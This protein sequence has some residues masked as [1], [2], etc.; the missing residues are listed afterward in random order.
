MNITPVN[1][2]SFGRQVGANTLIRLAGNNI[3]GKPLGKSYDYGAKAIH[4]I[5]D[6]DMQRSTSSWHNIM[7]KAADYI[8]E[9]FPEI[10][11]TAKRITALPVD[12]RNGAEIEKIMNEYTSKFGDVVEVKADDFKRAVLGPNTPKFPKQKAKTQFA[13]E[14][15]LPAKAKPETIKP[16]K[17]AAQPVFIPPHIDKEIAYKYKYAMFA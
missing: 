5:A 13:A 12:K 1:N 14:H 4:L 3:T 8:Q 16:A 17:P 7:I 6:I 9:K 2:V 11:K 10:G 15:N